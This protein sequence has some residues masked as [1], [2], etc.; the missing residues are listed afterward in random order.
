MSFFTSTIA[1]FIIPYMII[2]SPAL[3]MIDT[4]IPQIIWVVFTAIT[5][6]IA[7]GA[8]VIGFWYRKLLWIERI[9]AIGAGL[10]LIYPEKF[11]DW[12][13]LGL[14]VILFIIQYLTQ[15]KLGGNGS[16]DQNGQ[17]NGITA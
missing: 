17:T 3:L 11:S 12:A 4:T 5:G 8:G 14:F 16:D 6:M 10:L 9:L 2:F 7:I 15:H 13:G 1:A